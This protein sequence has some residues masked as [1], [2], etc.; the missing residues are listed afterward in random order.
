MKK[1]I[2]TGSRTSGGKLVIFTRIP[3]F[4]AAVKL[5]DE[6]IYDALN[7]DEPYDRR[8]HVFYSDSFPSDGTVLFMYKATSRSARIRT[9]A[10]GLAD[11]EKTDRESF[12][13]ETDNGISPNG[14][15][16]IEL[17]PGVEYI[18]LNCADRHG[19]PVKIFVLTVEAGSARL[20][21]GT[22][23]DGFMPKNVRA[24]VPD[25]IAAAEKN[26][27]S[28]IAAVNADF[29]DMFGDSHPAGL[30]VKRGRVVANGFSDRPFVGQK[31]NGEYVIGTVPELSGG[32]SELETAVGG[33]ELIVDD[34]KLA[35]IGELEPFSSIRH[36]RTAAGIT[37][38][39]GLILAV[40]DGR[41]EEYSNGASLVDLADLMISFGAQRAVNLDGGGSCVMYIK[42]GGGMELQ[43][44]PAD[45]VR[46]RAKLIRKEF[47]CLILT[48]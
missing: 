4:C 35:D 23:D 48:A 45:L 38:G 28:P 47:D 36:P 22:P 7:A 27:V 6:V 17:A 5:G 19:L 41:I 8:T 33:L 46:P 3:V 24:K 11:A 31:R 39:G 1:G 26:G 30:C 12:I 18:A 44:V 37:R 10:V 29:F 42:T 15:T 13:A 14:E 2:V 32:L 34:G 40:V 16:R 21:T 43:N 20:Y 9:C 25:M